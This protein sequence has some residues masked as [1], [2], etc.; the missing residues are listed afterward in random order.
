MLGKPVLLELL[1]VAG[2]AVRP[3]HGYITMAEASGSNGG[4][5]RYKLKVQPWLVFAGVGRDSR[6]FHDKSVIEILDIVFS[7]YQLSGKLAAT[8]HLRSD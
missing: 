7:A 4:M 5:A 6:T 1:T 8:W 2:M 3:F